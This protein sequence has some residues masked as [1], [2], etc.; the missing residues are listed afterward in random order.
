MSTSVASCKSL[1]RLGKGKG[2]LERQRKEREGKS[3]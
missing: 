1:S 3:T 2:D